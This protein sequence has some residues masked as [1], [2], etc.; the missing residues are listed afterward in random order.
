M[1]FDNNDF[2]QHEHE[3]KRY[4][5]QKLKNFKLII[6]PPNKD[7]HSWKVNKNNCNNSFD[8]KIIRYINIFKINKFFLPYILV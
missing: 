1:F 3:K 8:L 7:Y 4:T 5:K 6:L 2:E